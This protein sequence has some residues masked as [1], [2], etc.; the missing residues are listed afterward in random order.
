MN[1]IDFEGLAL[2]PPTVVY[3]LP[4]GGRRLIQRATGYKHTIV[5]GEV[6][7]IEGEPTGKLNGNVIRGSQPAP[8]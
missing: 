1:V 3:D 2:H 8:N 7:F 6:A 5:S 4:A